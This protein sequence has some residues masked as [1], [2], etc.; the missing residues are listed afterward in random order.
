MT[1]AQQLNRRTKHFS[2]HIPVVKRRMTV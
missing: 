2:E 1:F